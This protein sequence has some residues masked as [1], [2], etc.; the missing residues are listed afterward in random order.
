MAPAEQS[1]KEGRYPQGNT[2][3]PHQGR[4]RKGK[5]CRARGGWEAGRG[6]VE[7]RPAGGVGGHIEALR[8]RR[9]SRWALG[10]GEGLGLTHSL[11]LDAA[12]LLTALSIPACGLN[13]I[14]DGQKG[15]KG[16]L[17][18][19]SL[20]WLQQPRGGQYMEWAGEL[21]GEECG[22][23]PGEGYRSEPLGSF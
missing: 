6:P 3:L 9:G 7:D 16:H 19:G 13:F 23:V 15:V 17:G 14:D 22:Q 5:A 8:P 2:G 11:Q 12:L 18:V 21:P 10:T 1:L 20:A 4:Q